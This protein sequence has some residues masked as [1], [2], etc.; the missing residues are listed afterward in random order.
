MKAAITSTIPGDA[1]P[2][3]PKP[4]ERSSNL[5]IEQ[6]RQDLGSSPFSS[7]ESDDGTG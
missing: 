4:K 2:T 3:F 6:I 7:V 5:D 1:P